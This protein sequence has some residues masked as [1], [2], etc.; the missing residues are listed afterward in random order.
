MTWVPRVWVLGET[1]GGGEAM[2]LWEAALCLVMPKGLW[3]SQVPPRTG[4]CGLEDAW[5]AEA[6]PGG[7]GLH[8]PVNLLGLARQPE[9]PQ[10]LPGGGTEPWAAGW[11]GNLDKPL[12]LSQ[13]C[14]FILQVGE[15]EPAI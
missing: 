8:H 15:S 13:A 2:V 3:R 5:V 12:C 7:K 14:L 1:R 6:V 9:A 4:T 11:V 10:E